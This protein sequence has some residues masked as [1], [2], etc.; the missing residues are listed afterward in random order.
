MSGKP[1]P[2]AQTTQK[3][4]VNAKDIVHTRVKAREIG[5]GISYRVIRGKGSKVTWS[6]L[7][8]MDVEGRGRD[9]AHDRKVLE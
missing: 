8:W 7:N 1:S 9:G 2:N 6:G 3:F 4:G 5:V